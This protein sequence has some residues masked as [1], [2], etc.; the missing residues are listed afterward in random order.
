MIDAQLRA[1]LSDCPHVEERSLDL[2]GLVEIEI[3]GAVDVRVVRGGPAVAVGAQ[4]SRD[5][6]GVS[7]QRAGDRVRI[8]SEGFAV[9][10]GNGRTVIAS[11]RGSIAIGGNANVVIASGAGSI[12]AGGD[13]FVNGVRVASSHAGDG[14]VPGPVVVAIAI[15]VIPEVTIAGAGN[16]ELRDLAQPSVLLQVTGSGDIEASGQ[17]ERVEVEIAG[18]GGIDAGNLVATEVKALISGSGDA[19]VHAT[20]AVRARVQ[21]SGQVRVSGN[22]PQRDTRIMGSGRVVFR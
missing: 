8:E 11:G 6:A 5:A 9:V 18:S 2:A 20:Q 19:R 1:I 7:L 12:A 16:V 22:P 3:A 21:G 4:V 17:V 13:V 15:P 14:H 10:A